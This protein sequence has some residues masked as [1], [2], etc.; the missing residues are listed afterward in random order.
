MESRNVMP[1][2]YKWFWP[3]IAVYLT[4]CA[5]DWLTFLVFPSLQQNAY[6]MGYRNIVRT[7]EI[8]EF[9]QGLWTVFI[10][11]GLITFVYWQCHYVLALPIAV[12]LKRKRK[13][14]ELVGSGAS[15]FSTDEPCEI[16]QQQ[17]TNYVQ[18]S[19]IIILSD[20]TAAQMQGAKASREAAARRLRNAWRD[21]RS[22]GVLRESLRW[23]VA[24]LASFPI[25]PR[26]NRE[27]V[28]AAGNKGE[29]LVLSRLQSELPTSWKFIKGYRNRKGEIDLIAVG[30][31]GVAAVEVKYLNGVVHCSG[32]RWTRDKYDNYGNLM[33]SAS[34]IAD[35]GG[36]A[37][38]RQLNEPAAVLE[39]FLFRRAVS[40]KIARVVVLS[41]AMSRLGNLQGVT[42]DRIC[43]L[44]DLD[45][46]ALCRS[47]CKENSDMEIGRIVTLIKE[48]HGS[49]NRHDKC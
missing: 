16:N 11:C 3:I 29:E 15:M 27:L 19:R 45:L 47:K 35:K 8:R 14:G 33:E 34:V 30:P 23:V 24:V 31:T 46:A 9:P 44:H 12:I 26:R 7:G 36:R 6:F 37:P 28:F 4:L 25:L 20:Y 40:G 21:R 39:E 13:N 42:V 43:T 38:S 2:L 22:F 1:A 49:Y 17:A 10:V 48:N 18:D 32:D 41:H 5:F